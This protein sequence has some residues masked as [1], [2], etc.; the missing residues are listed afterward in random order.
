MEVSGQH[1]VPVTLCL[2]RNPGTQEAGKWDPRASL[3]VLRKEN[4]VFS[5]PGFES[6]TVQSVS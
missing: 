5:P 6:P 1:H 3:D 4:N 2:K